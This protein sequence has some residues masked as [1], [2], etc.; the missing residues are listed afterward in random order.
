MTMLVAILMFLSGGCFGAAV[1]LMIVRKD[2]RHV[3]YTADSE[4]DLDSAIIKLVAA[5][6]RM[7]RT[8]D[9]VEDKA[10]EEAAE[11]RRMADGMENMLNFDPMQDVKV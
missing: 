8:C 11:R 5:A 3:E 9:L 2:L 6:R 10:E 7:E 1:M 4:H